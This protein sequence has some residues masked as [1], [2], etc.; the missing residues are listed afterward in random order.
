MLKFVQRLVAPKP[1]P[2]G[3]SLGTDFLRLA[4]VQQVDAEWRLVAAAEA[5]VPAEARKEAASRL[6]FFSDMAKT[7][8]SHGGFSGRQVI[9]AMPAAMM[10][11][12]H[13][14]LP[15]MDEESLRKA[16]PW[17]LRGKMPIDPSR[18]IMRHIVAGEVYQDRE[19]SQEVVVLAAPKDAIQQYV[20][21]A[22]RAR[23]DV[24]GMESDSLA[25]VNS[26]GMSFKG[27]D[28]EPVVGLVDIGAAGTRLVIVQ[29]GH[30]LFA[31]FIAIGGAAI[32]KGGFSAAAAGD[33]PTTEIRAGVASGASA[34]SGEAGSEG[35]GVAMAEMLRVGQDGRASLDRL[36]EELELCRR[37]HDAAFPN[38]PIERLVFVGGGAK[39]RAWCQQLAR[40]LNIAAQVGDALVRLAKPADVSTVGSVDMRQPQPAWAVA[41]GLVL[42]QSPR[43]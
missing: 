29:G 8:L 25:I 28:A 19:P 41:I 36:G 9:L 42:G 12:Q 21:T 37:Y 1:S 39:Q 5:E 15:K 26:V 17:E 2:I 13:L 11:A 40:R 6:E 18:A 35:T 34:G 33:E 31:R 14:R 16:L 7:M 43:P 3:V 22:E 27:K 20:K 30:V 32:A 38:R 10:C 4:Q 23:L 24:V